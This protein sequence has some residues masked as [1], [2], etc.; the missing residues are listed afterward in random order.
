MLTR[1]FRTFAVTA[2]A[3]GAAAAPAA[4]DSIVYVRD[5]NLHLTSP[6]GSRGYQVTFDGGYSSPSQ[7]DDGTIGALRAGQ[8]VRMDRSGNLLNE[9]I[10]AVGSPGAAWSPDIG[11]PYE[12]RISPDGKRFAYWVYVRSITNDYAEN[13]SFASVG[14]LSTWTW[15]DRFTS[16]TEEGE[17]EKSLLQPEWVTNDRL[18]GQM[19][20]WMNIWTWKTGTG[21]G[22]TYDAAQWWFGLQDP[23]DEWGVEAYH[24]Y[25]DPALSPDGRKLALTDGDHAQS[26]LLIA[27][28]NGPAW[29]GEPPYPEPDYVGGT[30]ALQRP[31]LECEAA[32]GRVVN[33][34][35]SRDGGT[36]A[37]GGADGVH[38]VTVPDSFAC[39]EMKDVVLVPGGSE[40][41]FGPADVDTAQ[42]PRRGAAAPPAGAPAPTPAAAP[43]PPAATLSALTV[44]PRA[45]RAS[46]G[47]RVSFTLAAPGRV[48]LT[49]QRR[50][51]R[52]VPGS[53]TRTGR[54]GVNTI[55]FTGRIGGRA[56]KRGSYR[57]IV[58]AGAAGTVARAPFTI[59]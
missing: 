18:L 41:A 58:S 46:R 52:R 24:Y 55:R 17:Y 48:R 42:A 29:Q 45:F 36:L 25:D 53:I 51:G 14:S 33:P 20:M 15:A 10:D 3:A 23:V 11:G 27:R 31:T 21:K 19:D 47:T 49:V 39:G 8:L 28:T 12:P 30:N 6:D 32:T 2:I 5:G 7:A 43:G 4:A 37:Y 57:L 9:P 35:W 34:S 38:T 44:R 26:R 54:A 59:R 1:L 56:L 16:P 50:S 13:K 40:P 22:Y